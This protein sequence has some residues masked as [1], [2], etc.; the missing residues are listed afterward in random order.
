LQVIGI[1]YSTLS[2]TAGVDKVCDITIT[3][4]NKLISSGVTY[5]HAATSVVTSI[6]PQF[7][8]STGG[9]VLHIVG[10][11]FIAGSTITVTI[12]GIDCPVANHTDT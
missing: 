2:V 1:K 9:D 7:G 8:P 6:T 4:G 5:A 11:G 10:T 3:T 12:D